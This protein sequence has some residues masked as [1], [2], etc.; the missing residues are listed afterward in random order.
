MRCSL[1]L[2]VLL[3]SVFW[4][5]LAPAQNAIDPLEVARDALKADRQ[6]LVASLMQLTDE[7]ATDSW[8][9]YHQYRV[10]MDLVGDGLIKLVNQYAELHA[11]LSEKDARRLTNDYL[12][13]EKKYLQTRT[14]YFTRI[15]EVLPATKTLRFIQ[16]DSRFDLVV[17]LQLAGGLPLASGKKAGTE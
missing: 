11:N 12:D 3:G 13:L 4:P 10:A 1:G 6:Q 14:L 16:I 5:S 15:G 7:E 8:P 9:I 2:I 17:R